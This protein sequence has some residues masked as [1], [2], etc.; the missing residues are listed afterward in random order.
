LIANA[1]PPPTLVLHHFAGVSDRLDRH[2]A[3][4]DAKHT[5]IESMIRNFPR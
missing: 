1:A 3:A 2:I 4:R 5:E